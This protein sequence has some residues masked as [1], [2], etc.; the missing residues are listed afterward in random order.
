[1]A[2]F[3]KDSRLVH[4]IESLIENADEYLFLFSPYIQLHERVKQLLVKLG[5]SKPRVRIS[6]IFGKN[7]DNLHKSISLNDLEFLKALPNIYVGYEKRLHAKFYASEDFSII[8]SMNLHQFSSN[9]NIEVGI[10][11][12]TGLFGGDLSSEEAALDYFKTVLES[13]NELFS[14]EPVF[15]S[16]LMGTVKKYSHS[17]IKADNCDS[18]F[19]KPDATFKKVS[20][21]DIPPEESLKGFCIR[22]GTKIPYDLKRPMS[23]E[24]FALWNKFKNMD[25]PEKYCHKTG[26][27]SHGKTS[28]RNPVLRN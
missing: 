25:Y 19:K 9:N 20:P 2:E 15:T 11:L 5:L 17:E 23:K 21:S 16:S 28:M 26:A 14:R 10:K 6:I 3:L 13:S 24:A 18:F 1:M 4:E 8:T 27:L 22:S 7:E 12:R